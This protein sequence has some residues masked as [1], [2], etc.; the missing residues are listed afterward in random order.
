MPLSSGHWSLTHFP[1]DGSRT[2][3][4]LYSLSCEPQILLNQGLVPDWDISL[5]MSRSK[6]P[7]THWILKSLILE[8]KLPE[9]EVTHSPPIH[10]KVNYCRGTVQCSLAYWDNFY[11]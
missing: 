9:N 2:Q 5:R 3:P 7:C 11:C 10:A 6:Q 1:D 4:A 8:V